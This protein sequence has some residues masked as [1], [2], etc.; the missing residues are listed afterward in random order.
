MNKNVPT[1]HTPAT[2]FHTEQP[3]W[4]HATVNRTHPADLCARLHLF[5]SHHNLKSV[6][7]YF[8]S[9]LLGFGWLVVWTQCTQ[10]EL[11]E[12]QESVLCLPGTQLIPR[13]QKALST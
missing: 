3:F 13:A 5:L 4:Y 12:A 6:C 8:L 2:L 9:L 10:T 11:Y 1:S 7:F